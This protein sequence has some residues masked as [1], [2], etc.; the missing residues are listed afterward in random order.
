M[1]EE[2]TIGIRSHLEPADPSNP[3][4]REDIV[5]LAF[6]YMRAGSTLNEAAIRSGYSPATIWRW[7]H[8]DAN[9]QT[10]YAQLKNQRSQALIEHAIYELQ[11]A[12][13]LEQVKCAERR[14]RYYLLIAA[15]LNPKE[16]S[17]RMHS[18]T[19]NRQLGNGQVSFVLN[20]TGAS[21]QPSRELTVVAQP[22]DGV[23]EG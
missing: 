12:S 17:D 6:E 11:S 5:Q 18:P 23:E 4:V 14:A 7:I 3:P 19:G 20:F 2:D 8:L 10:L 16:F 13:T 15:K 1:E 22:E 9:L 21:P